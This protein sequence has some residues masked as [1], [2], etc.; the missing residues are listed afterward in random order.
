M[1]PGPFAVLYIDFYPSTIQPFPMKMIILYFKLILILCANASAT[2]HAQAK[3]IISENKLAAYLLDFTSSPHPMG[4]PAQKSYAQ[5]L[6]KLLKK[7]GWNARLQSFT[8]VT[9][10]PDDKTKKKTQKLNG[11]NVVASRKGSENCAVLIGGHFDTK[12]YTKIKFVGANDGGSS[13]ALIMELARVLKFVEKSKGT[14]TACDV[15]LVLFDG[16]ESQLDEWSAGQ[17]FFQIQDNLYG[18]TH[19]VK[20]YPK[21]KNRLI[22]QGKPLELALIIDMIGHKNQKL[23]ITSGSH[24][25][26][27]KKLIALRGNVLINE[28]AQPVEDDHVPFLLTG[29]PVIHVI[30]WTNLAEWH[31]D[32]DTLKIISTKKIAEF[33]DVLLKFLSEKR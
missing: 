10:V 19:F 12:F 17:Q 22:V 18:S 3:E 31:T 16:E 5:H 7:L 9:P 11:Y 26:L 25:E 33:G 8:A 13:T 21:R 4:S 29:T 27:S 32:K 24:S 15:H 28:L 1:Y 23:S 6:E 30:D 2:A 20:S 14:W